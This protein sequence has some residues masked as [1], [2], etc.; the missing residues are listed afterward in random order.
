MRH[1][2][3][4][5]LFL[6]SL[7]SPAQAQSVGNANNFVVG[8][9]TSAAYTGYGDIVTSGWYAYL[10]L[11][12]AFKGSTVGNSCV[13]I[14]RTSDSTQCTLVTNSGTGTSQ[15]PYGGLA[16]DV[17][18]PCAGSTTAASWCASTTCYLVESFDQSGNSNNTTSGGQPT[19]VFSCKGSLPCWQC[20]M[21]SGSSA[22]CDF[23]I[24]TLTSPY[25]P[26]PWNVLSLEEITTTGATIWG[27]ISASGTNSGFGMLWNSSG[28]VWLYAGSGTV[29][30]SIGANTWA[31]FVGVA[32]G[33]SSIITANGSQS[34]SV[35]PGSS[36]L[37]TSSTLF[38]GFRNKGN[39]TGNI[40]VMEM[41]LIGANSGSIALTA[42]QACSL[43]DNEHD[44]YGF[45]W[46]KC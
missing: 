21:T 20:P 35:N 11:T 25:L 31:S 33:S 22:T 23:T 26:Q 43:I 39:A 38:W 29:T 1:I 24:P 12:R 13:K 28:A 2:L 34:T 8:A 17:G 44:Y 5:A 27:A 40:N 10:C 14:E 9:V 4:L 32:N 16:V 7:C 41:G 19:L 30:E 42:A 3:A 45:S 37:G 18:T 36:A 6:A 46:S 15:S